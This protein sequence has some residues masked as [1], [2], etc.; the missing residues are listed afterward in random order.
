MRHKVV[1]TGHLQLTLR[2]GATLRDCIGFGLGSR[3]H[4]LA[5]GARL[6]VAFVPEIDQHRGVRKIRLRVR[7][8]LA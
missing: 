3:S 5:S 2:T 6:L 4:E 7:D 1:G 8:L